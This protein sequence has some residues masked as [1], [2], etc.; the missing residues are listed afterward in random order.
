M[1]TPGQ[2]FQQLQQQVHVLTDQVQT[3]TTS[4]SR[5][6]ACL[7]EPE[8]FNGTPTKWDTWLP[9]I[10]AKLLVDADSI[11]NATAQFYY[12][13]LNLES[14]AQSLVLPQLAAAKA[15]QSWNYQTILDQL[16]RAYDS[17]TK[18]QEAEER[19]L[20]CS[21]GTDNLSTYIARFERLLYEARVQSWPDHSKIISFRQG[22]NSTIRG[23][24][25]SQLSLPSTYSEYVKTVQQL[26]SRSTQYATPSFE[27]KGPVS[28][29]KPPIREPYHQ[30]R[31]V[32]THGGGD[33]MDIGQLNSIEIN[34]LG[35]VSPAL[36][37]TNVM[38]DV[39][40]RLNVID[41]VRYASREQQLRW[42]QQ[43]VCMNCG[44]EFHWSKDCLFRD[45][46]PT[47]ARRQ[48]YEPGPYGYADP[49]DSD[50]EEDDDV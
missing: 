12:V 33:P 46:I 32:D 21:Q 15:S 17:P 4:R 27:A 30:H 23:R 19:L 45:S 37:N 11:G 9:S 39:Q 16:A 42:K 29:L 3:L 49:G 40:A 6:K 22:L 25:N 13:Y 34:H 35:E 31:R 14:Q 28:I 8:K 18:V 1:A 24:L 20:K 50:E 2:Q 10:E 44:D 38:A 43:G 7:P 47:T 5:P 48:L 41:G 26:S 36:T